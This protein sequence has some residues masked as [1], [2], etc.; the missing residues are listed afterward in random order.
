M[1]ITVNPDV[2]ASPAFVRE[3]IKRQ[4]E[5]SG[6]VIKENDTVVC[7][8]I[9]IRVEDIVKGFLFKNTYHKWWWKVI[10]KMSLNIENHREGKY[11]LT[12]E[13]PADEAALSLVYMFLD[14]LE[15]R[16][17]QSLNSD[18]ELKDCIEVQFVRVPAFAPL[19][20]HNVPRDCY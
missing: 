13:L 2:I 9:P 19:E 14:G 7:E 5:S 3:Q 17:Q 12:I 10:Y 20:T 15:Q 11:K 8:Q 6:F 16:V 1:N 18:S 4:I